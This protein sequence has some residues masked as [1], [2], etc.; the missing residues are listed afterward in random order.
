LKKVLDEEDRKRN[1]IIGETYKKLTEIV[2]A[3]KH[4]QDCVNETELYLKELDK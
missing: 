2:D 3:F 4:A 1:G